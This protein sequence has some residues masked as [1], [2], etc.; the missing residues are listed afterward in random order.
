[1][2]LLVLD[3]LIGLFACKPLVWRKGESWEYTKLLSWGP[4]HFLKI[5]KKNC[6]FFQYRRFLVEISTPEAVVDGYLGRGHI[7]SWFARKLNTKLHRLFFT[8]TYPPLIVIPCLLMLLRYIFFSFLFVPERDCESH[9][10]LSSPE[11]DGAEFCPTRHHYKCSKDGWRL[12]S[13][14]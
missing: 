2:S 9:R 12:V 8:T 11:P 3:Q 1:M 7:D 6:Y 5:W 10:W 14:Y 13:Q 4:T